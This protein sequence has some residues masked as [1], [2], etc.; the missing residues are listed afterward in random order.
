[1]KRGSLAPLAAQ[2]AYHVVPGGMAGLTRLGAEV[3]V[4]TTLR[5][6]FRREL[7]RMITES[8]ACSSAH[9]LLATLDLQE[10]RLEQARSHLVEARRVDPLV[11]L[12]YT[13]LA[14]LEKSQGHWTAALEDFHR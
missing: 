10:G 4:D 1:R 6:D 5:R 11:P 12:Y 3:P 13:R 14:L 8:A 2:L 9:S 7:D